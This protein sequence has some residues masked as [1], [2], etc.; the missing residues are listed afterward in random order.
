MNEKIYSRHSSARQL[1]NKKPIFRGHLLSI[2]MI[3]IQNKSVDRPN[4]DKGD[5]QD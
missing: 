4:F 5:L 2:E 3:G 1:F